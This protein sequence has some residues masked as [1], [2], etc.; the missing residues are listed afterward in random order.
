MSAKKR[1]IA[2]AAENTSLIIEAGED[3]AH[4][5]TPTSIEDARDFITM[6]AKC[7]TEDAVMIGTTELTQDLGR[8]KEEM[9]SS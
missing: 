2:L 3:L 7:N 5:L 4:A 6:N 8:G 9:M 1:S